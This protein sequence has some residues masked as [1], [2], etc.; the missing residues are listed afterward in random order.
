MPHKETQIKV[1]SS[2]GWDKLFPSIALMS[3]G[4]L[5]TH[6]KVVVGGGSFFLLSGGVI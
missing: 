6:R 1:G 2:A 5:D 4:N 3:Y